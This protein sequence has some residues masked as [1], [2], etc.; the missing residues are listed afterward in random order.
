MWLIRGTWLIPN[1]QWLNN[2]TYHWPDL[3]LE[4]F[5]KLHYKWEVT[6]YTMINDEF[7]PHPPKTSGNLCR[8]ECFFFRI[9]FLRFSNQHHA[10]GDS[11]IGSCLCPEVVSTASWC[12]LMGV[13]FGRNGKQ[14]DF[15][16]WKTSDS[17]LFGALF[18]IFPPCWKETTISGL[19]MNHRNG[20]GSSVGLVKS[21]WAHCAL[22]NEDVYPIE[23]KICKYVSSVPTS[24]IGHCFAP[25][26]TKK[27][28]Q[29]HRVYFDNRLGPA[30]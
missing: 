18:P 17:S 8:L 2:F 10:P 11:E 27:K 23:V 1:F 12:R 4:S 30:M 9:H 25:P 21:S 29:S 14:L 3:A 13:F 7:K 16:W 22:E 6:I 24:N 28:N 26:P 19:L 20:E 15:Y 5:W